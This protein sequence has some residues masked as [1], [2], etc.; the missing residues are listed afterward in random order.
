MKKINLVCLL[1]AALM[2]LS[3]C[4]VSA[5]TFSSDFSRNNSPEK[6]PSSATPHPSLPSSSVSPTPS[7]PPVSPDPSVSPSP[8]RLDSKDIPDPVL[9][10]RVFIPLGIDMPINDY[11]LEDLLDDLKYCSAIGEAAAICLARV[12]KLD[13]E[14]VERGKPAEKM[15]MTLKIRNIYQSTKA[16]DQK[17]TSVGDT[18]TAA[19]LHLLWYEQERGYGC[20]AGTD[21]VFPITE[22]GYDYIVFL[23]EPYESMD[24]DVDFCVD[25]YSMPLSEYSYDPLYVAKMY[26]LLGNDP[27]LYCLPAFIRYFYLEDFPLPEYN[28]KEYLIWEILVGYEKRW[29]TP[30]PNA[31]ERIEWLENNA[32]K[33]GYKW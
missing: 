15:T 31:Q 19:Q 33:Y 30:Y 11:Y 10:N 25:A 18:V 9:Q 13:L 12:E 1:L 23:T 14:S 8:S 2:I 26:Y 32:Q 20:F 21:C 16:F 27:H 28:T 6:E 3:S 4:A 22:Q 29:G 17:G 7:L 24:V 5:S